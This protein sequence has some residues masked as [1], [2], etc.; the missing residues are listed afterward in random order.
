MLNTLTHFRIH[1]IHSAQ[2]IF[3][4][5]WRCKDLVGRVCRELE[6]AKHGLYVTLLD[7]WSS[8]LANAAVMENMTL[9]FADLFRPGSMPTQVLEHLGGNTHN[10]HLLLDILNKT[11]ASDTFARLVQPVQPS[12]SSA[13]AVAAEPHLDFVQ[14]FVRLVRGCLAVPGIATTAKSH[15][16]LRGSNQPWL[17]KLVRLAGSERSRHP[18]LAEAVTAL[19]A[20]VTQLRA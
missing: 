6:A 15:V 8:C 12:S 10:T 7:A 19:S 20:A 9:L 4:Q 16:F 11:G 13:A 5:T 18:H 2:I 1:D 17:G 3:E 14:D